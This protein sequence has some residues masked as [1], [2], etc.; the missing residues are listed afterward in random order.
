MTGAGGGRREDEKIGRSRVAVRVLTGMLQSGLPRG[1]S[2]AALALIGSPRLWPRLGPTPIPV[3]IPRMTSP[4]GS[5][6]LPVIIFNLAT[7]HG[8]YASP[9]TDTLL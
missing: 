6:R 5:V 7:G 8:Q 4:A 3:A 1:W 2:S 9:A